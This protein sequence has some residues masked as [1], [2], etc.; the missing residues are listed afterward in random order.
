MNYFKNHWTNT[1]LVC[2]HFNAFIML[3]LKWQ[4]N[5]KILIFFPSFLEKVG[6]VSL[7]SAIMGMS[8]YTCDSGLTLVTK[9]WKK[10][11]IE[12]SSF[13][14]ILLLLLLLFFLFVCLFCFCFVLFLAGNSVLPSK[15]MCKKW[16]EIRSI[17][18]EIN[19]FSS[20]VYNWKS[21]KKILC[22]FKG[23]ILHIFL[24]IIETCFL[25]AVFLIFSH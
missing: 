6:Q 25:Y 16:R 17:S 24:L 9:P 22:A 14:T 5:F 2:T 8:N 20:P 19:I 18:W 7:M 3:S 12:K 11:G 23:L 10:C 21:K 1:R 13:P 15:E 4:W